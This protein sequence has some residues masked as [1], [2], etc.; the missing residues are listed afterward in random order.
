MKNGGAQLLF[1]RVEYPCALA[2]RLFR[3]FEEVSQEIEVA[4]LRDARFQI[5]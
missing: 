1:F 5:P 2:S 4:A 3:F